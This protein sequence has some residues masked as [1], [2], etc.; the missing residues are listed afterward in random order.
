MTS[1]YIPL[2][3]GVLLIAVSSC[4]QGQNQSAALANGNPADGNLAPVSAPAP[5]ATAAS[6]TYGAPQSAPEPAEYA[7]ATAPPPAL[8]DYSQPP[9]PG[10]DYIWTPG[11]W[12]YSSAGYYWVPGA[13]VLAPW[14]G[15]LWTPPWWGY[16]NGVYVW[17]AGYW[18]PHIGFYGGINYGYGYTGRGYYGAY[19]NHGSVFY[20]RAVTNVNAAIHHVYDYPVAHKEGGRV[21]YN[22]GRGGIEARP[23]PEE[24]AVAHDPRTVAV[25]AQVEHAR[26]ASADR[27]QFANRGEPHPAALAVNRPLATSYRSP[28][29]HPP[30]AAIHE[31]ARSAP[32]SRASEPPRPQERTQPVPPGISENQLPRQPLQRPEARPA[33]QAETHIPAPTPGRPLPQ[34]LPRPEARPVPQA[35]NHPPVVQNRTPVEQPP[36]QRGNRPAPAARPAPENRPQQ[37]KPRA[38]A[39]PEASREGPPRAAPQ[40]RPEPQ[41]APPP[42][43]APEEK[44]KEL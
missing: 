29:A 44:R 2:A 32:E 12:S 42:P 6:E 20:N 26:Q 23:S 1:K 39:P 10:E 35:P 19:W 28:A 5:G 30:T 16:D 41:R 14:V 31:A 21:A 17:H 15:A 36:P 34:P 11:Y 18:G 13:W 7:Q 43:R 22:G 40:A 27:A 25:A 24:L 4:N 37:P 38:Q 33:P 9:C 8:P 3:I